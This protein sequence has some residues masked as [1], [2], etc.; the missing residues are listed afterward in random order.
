MFLRRM[1]I[2]QKGILD[3]PVDSLN[4]G[5][6]GKH[7]GKHGSKTELKQFSFIVLGV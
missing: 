3:N 7:K 5:W 1:V 4:G 6:T 2:Y